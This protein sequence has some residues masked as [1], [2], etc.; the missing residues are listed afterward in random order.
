MKRIFEG[1]PIIYLIAS[2]IPLLSISIFLADLICSALAVLFLFYLIK[3]NFNFVYKNTFFIISIIFYFVCVISSIFSDD[4]LFSL[5]SSLPL[6]R[7]ISFLFLLS[8]LITFNKDL[9]DVFY[10]FIKVT[11]LI[12]ILSGFV[13][14]FYKYNLL[15][16]LGVADLY[17]RHIR[18]DLFVFI[19]DEEKLGSFLVRIYGLF[20]ALHIVKKNKSKN[21]N[22]FFFILT[23]LTAIII[24]LSGERTSLFFMILFSFICL[25][26]LNIK[27]KTKLIFLTLISTCFFLLLF[28][29]T[30]LSQRIIG[31]KGNQFS[32]S[33]NEVIIFTPAHTAHYKAA[34]KMFLDKPYL[35]HG[36]RMFR[37]ICWDEIYND[38]FFL[39]CGQSRACSTHPHNTYVQLLAETGIIG[40]ILFTS[41]FIYI[42]Y[43]LL[44]HFLML[45]FYR[46]RYL[47]DYQI[48]LSA[49]VL[50]TFWPFSPSGNF[51]NNWMLIVYSIPLGFYINE[52]WR[53]KR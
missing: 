22:I 25:I 19:S 24:L 4:I 30:N 23:L 46:K 32:F 44:K 37:L 2:I 20:L 36:P 28:L 49:T 52:F 27:F 13:D 7:I 6:I 38:C 47:V 8:Y 51:F 50:I 16:D 41:G 21:Q 53:F 42:T 40:T 11:F 45:I 26:L 33:K 17:G 31:D 14:Y 3:S 5:K 48:V 18:L 12:L 1:K 9:I 10:N 29:N 43:T 34:L 15:A 39:V 35:G